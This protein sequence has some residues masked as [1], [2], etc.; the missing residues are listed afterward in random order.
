MLLFAS[1]ECPVTFFGQKRAD[2]RKLYHL[3]GRAQGTTYHIRYFA[4]NENVEKHEVDSIFTEID[5]SLSIYKEN[6]LI[7]IFNNSISGVEMD[8]HLH[9][10]VAKS[11]D[12]SKK[13]EGIFDI[14]I[15]PLVQLWGF[16]TRKVQAFPDS[17]AVKEYMKCVGYH[18]L[19]IKGN[20]LLK[21]DPCVK[22]NVNAIAPGY[23]SD[24]IARFLD[25]RKIK[26]Y[27]V[28]VGGELR[29][30][31]T[32]PD[33]SLSSIGIEGP[34]SNVDQ[35]DGSVLQRIVK[36]KKG[37]MTT[38]GNY[39]QYRE[40]GNRRVSHLLDA[41]TG[42]PVE[43]ELISVTVLAKDAMTADAYDNVLMGL[44]LEKS[45]Q[46][47]KK[48]KNMEAYF[49]YKKADGSVA[50]TATLGFYKVLN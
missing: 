42:Y 3:S 34:A 20:R 33:G 2:D 46:F 1:G 22:I 36:I 43:N 24:L 29:I 27:V 47:L 15:Y 31:G 6:T 48:E 38:A 13:S 21:T 18:K 30:K 16:G 44:G 50:D 12:V 14:S 28:E 19:Y 41:R 8:E 35:M 45:F 5:R 11:L 40:E 26:T 17:L 4:D 39:R 25:Q 37:A 10:V 9:R 32:K 23:T 49:I 7:S